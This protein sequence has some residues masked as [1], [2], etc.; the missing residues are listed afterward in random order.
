MATTNPIEPE[1]VLVSE[2]VIAV[3][4]AQRQRLAARASVALEELIHR[5][6]DQR[7]HTNYSLRVAA[8]INIAAASMVLQSR[9]QN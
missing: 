6:E 1:L 4:H 9:T 5:A 3:Y 7:N 2:Q 8:E